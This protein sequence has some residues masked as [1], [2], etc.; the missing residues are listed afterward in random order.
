M[1]LVGAFDALHFVLRPRVVDEID[2]DCRCD[3]CGLHRRFVAGKRE[4]LEHFSVA[5]RAVGFMRRGFVVAAV[6]V[7]NEIFAR[8]V[9]PI[10]RLCPWIGRR[11]D[12]DFLV[13]WRCVKNCSR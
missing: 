5:T 10:G 6:G 11:P 2:D 1:E 4:Q 8:E 3:G 13:S 9:F 12:S 7:A